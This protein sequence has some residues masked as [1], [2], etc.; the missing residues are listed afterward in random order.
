MAGQKTVLIVG[1]SRGLG[2]ALAQEYCDKDWHVIATVRSQSAQ[3][4]ALRE[5]NPCSLEIHPVDIVDVQSVRDLRARLD[6]RRL[7]TLFVNAGICKANELTPLQVDEQDFIDMMLT[8]ALSPMR[9]IELFADTVASDGVIAVM[10]SDLGSI[11]WNQ[12][13]WE[14]YSASKAALNMLMKAYAARHPANTRALLLV[15]PGWVRTD[16]GGQNA[17]LD[18]SESIPLVVDMVQRHAG[19]PGLRFT[20]RH[21]ETLPW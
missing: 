20:N 6:G 5:R 16:M 1:A 14:L 3:L 2:L 21:G 17:E 11:T 15:A 4:E 8:N 9:V 10:S 12:G 19:K 18:V 7:D 13:W